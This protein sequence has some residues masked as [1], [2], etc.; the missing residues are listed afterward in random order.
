MPTVSRQKYLKKTQ[1]RKSKLKNLRLRYASA[2]S[3]DEKAKI[4]EKA[5]KIAI[6]LSS[7]DFVS[8]VKK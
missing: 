8:P 2:K 5:K 3:E 1:Q 4:V 7:E 6:W